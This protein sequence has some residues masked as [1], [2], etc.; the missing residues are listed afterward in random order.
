MEES[1]MATEE[2]MQEGMVRIP[3]VY[4]GVEDVPIH[5]ANQFVIQHVQG[6]FVLM[7]GQ[8]TPP[9]LLG[10]DEERRTQAEKVAYVPVKVV[11]RVAFSRER[12]VE[13]IEVLREHL[14]KYD[15]QRESE[16]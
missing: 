11:A 9:V 16:R 1:G 2:P 4:V 10:T 3:L 8:M 7:L 6:D 15:T 12:L 5:F 13:L 14:R